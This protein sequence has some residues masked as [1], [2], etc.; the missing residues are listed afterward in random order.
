MNGL[1]LGCSYGWDESKC[2]LNGLEV[3]ESGLNGCLRW[4][5]GLARVIGG[6]G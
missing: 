5:L 3:R 1:G 2:D 6:F 4:R